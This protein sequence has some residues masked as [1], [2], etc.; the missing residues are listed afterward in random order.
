M[1]E[2]ADVAGT[3]TVR[4]K[5]LGHELAF[6]RGAIKQ[7]EAAAHI[8]R[9]RP[10]L[11]QVEA[12]MSNLTVG[13]LDRLLTFYGV[14]DPG[15]IEL[16][17]EWRRTS[18]QP[19]NY[20]SGHR[21][22]FSEDFHTFVEM[23]RD[24]DLLRVVSTELVPDWLQTPEYME[25]LL[26]AR[27]RTPQYRESVV[28]AR[29]ERQDVF[30]GAGAVAELRI[31]MSESCLRRLVGS[32]EVMRRQ[33]EHIVR[34]SERPNVKI[35]I[36]PFDYTPRSYLV[37]DRFALFR[38]PSPGLA[39]PLQYVCNMFEGIDRFF[40][41]DDKEAVNSHESC[42]SSQSADALQFEQTRA[43]IEK[44]IVPSY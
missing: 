39:G 7:E 44:E 21:A 26:A 12:G 1:H 22:V 37:N 20:W 9:K 4:K 34:A 5:L 40:Y 11:A 36:Q 38:V 13:D 24:C 27:K 23:E 3:P 41:N 31:V 15:E 33:A 29:L 6:L 14:T 28:K 42:F 35:Q 18:R 25:H 10:Y 8:E 19:R 32:P 16:C 30:F 43:Y 2:E 17:R